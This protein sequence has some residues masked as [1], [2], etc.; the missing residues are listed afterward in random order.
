MYNKRRE[1]YAINTNKTIGK[2]VH[3]TSKEEYSV[4]VVTETWLAN[5]SRLIVSNNPTIKIRT[6][7][8]WSWKYSDWDI[9]LEFT[10][11]NPKF[12]QKGNN[13]SKKVKYLT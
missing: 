6:K 4:I 5:K 2:I 3:Q 12:D 9:I 7:D 1:G 10:G 11:W 13:F 8:V